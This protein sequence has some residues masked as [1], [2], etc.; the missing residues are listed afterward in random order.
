VTQEA[1]DKKQLLPML[2]QV[3]VAHESNDAISSLSFIPT[4][5]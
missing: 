3:A 5:S 2:E 1:N 4:H